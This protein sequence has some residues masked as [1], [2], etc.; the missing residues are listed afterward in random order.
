M[1]VQ[2]P[3]LSYKQRIYIQALGFR[4]GWA[5]RKIAKDQS[6]SVSV[7][8]WVCKGPSTPEKK[9]KKKRVAL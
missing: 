6:I 4:A 3:R 8:W 9:K 5:L 7:V 2:T 1:P